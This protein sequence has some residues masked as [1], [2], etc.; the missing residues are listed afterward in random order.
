MAQKTGKCCSRSVRFPPLPYSKSDQAKDRFNL[1]HSLERK[2]GGRNFGE[3]QP[4][5]S[6]LPPP[7]KLLTN[8]AMKFAGK[9]WSDSQELLSKSSPSKQFAAASLTLVESFLSAAISSTFALASF[10]FA[11]LLISCYGLV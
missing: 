2:G 11:Q 9:S 8:L 6:S 5:F 7:P 1:S 4:F 10:F 3:K